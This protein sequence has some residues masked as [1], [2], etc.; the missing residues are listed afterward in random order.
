MIKDY[1]QE[2]NKMT[3]KHFDLDFLLQFQIDHDLQVIRGSDY[4]YEC[5]IDKLCYNQSLTPIACIVLGVKKFMELTS[6]YDKELTKYGE[7]MYEFERSKDIFHK[8]KIIGEMNAI[9]EKLGVPKVE[10]KSPLLHI[11]NEVL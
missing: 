9:N 1:F 6:D 7:L 11:I 3:K 10:Y 5:W 8:R 2:E 4:N